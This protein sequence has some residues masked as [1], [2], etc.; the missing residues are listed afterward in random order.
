MKRAPG[1]EARPAA[2]GARL[3]T[4]EILLFFGIPAAVL[5]ASVLAI[6][7]AHGTWRVWVPIVH[8][9]GSRN[10]LA[11]VF[12]FAHA[13]RELPIDIVLGVAGGAAMAAAAPVAPS[14]WVDRRRWIVGAAAGAALLAILAGSQLTVGAAETAANLAQMPTRAGEPPVWGRHWQY[15]L[16]SRGAA[17]LLALTGA[18]AL[19]ARQTPHARMAG[20]SSA[21]VAVALIYLLLTLLFRPSTDPWIDP[22]FLGHQARELFTQS[23]TTVPLALGFCLWLARGAPGTQLVGRGPEARLVALFSG[24]GA[25]AV[26]LYLAIGV[27]VSDSYAMRQSDSF[28]PVVFGHFLESAPSYVLVPLIAGTVYLSA[29]PSR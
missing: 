5:L 26:G 23:L 14:P 2:A 15:H 9:D 16:L 18:A 7:L 20:S 12:Y 25:A 21:Y 28:V 6:A 3:S 24:S 11:T 22:L 10:L 8:E 4:A 29:H 17:M 19:R 1:G 13:A 27:H